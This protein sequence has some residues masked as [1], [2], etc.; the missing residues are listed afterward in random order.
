MI[1]RKKVQGRNQEIE[2]SNN[3]T[4]GVNLLLGDPKKAIVKLSI[5]A[6]MGQMAFALYNITDVVWVSGLGPDSLSAVGLFSPF[7]MLIGALSAGVGVGGGVLISHGIGSQD[8]KNVDNVALHTLVLM[9]LFSSVI[10]FLLLTFARPLL[11]V[12]GAGETIDLAVPYMK[13]MA[14]G[15]VFS[16]FSNV[17]NSILRAEGDVKRATYA[18]VSGLALNMILD[19]VFIYVLELGVAGAAWASLLSML[20]VS[21]VLFFWLCVRQDTFVSIDIRSFSFNKILISSILRIAVPVSISQVSNSII[22]FMT[23]IIVIRIVGTDGVAVYLSGMR[24]VFVAGLPV[25]GI[26]VAL[27]PVIGAAFGAQDYDKLG[28]AFRY[29][30]KIGLMLE[31]GAA[32][33][34]FVSAPLI[35]T[36]FTWSGESAGIAAELTLCLRVMMAVC[37]AMALS[38]LSGFSFVAVGKAYHALGVNFVRIFICVIPFILLFAVFLDFG[39]LGIWIGAAVGNWA[40]GIFAY[41]WAKKFIGAM[42]KTQETIKVEKATMAN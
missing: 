39:L 4:E 31:F 35:T 16:A 6:I 13:I 23:N 28:I 40:A 2:P 21:F 41:F 10:T 14:M 29:A 24:V 15:I 33:V 7:S 5:P 38:M 34:I 1:L 42:T 19:P 8:K 26:A 27:V 20:A 3:D 30:L 25:L 11:H 22:V 37:P 36:L 9:I 32:A 12:I 17:A 18:G